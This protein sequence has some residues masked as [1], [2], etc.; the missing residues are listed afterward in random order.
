MFASVGQTLSNWRSQ[1]LTVTADT[2]ELD[3]MS[4]VPS[5]FLVKNAKGEFLPK[6]DY[7]L[8]FSEAKLILK[9][10][11]R[12]KRLEIEYRVFPFSFAKPYAH[13][14]V[15]QLEP[16]DPGLYDYFTL[17]KEEPK[18]DPFAISGLNKNGSVSRGVNFGNSQDLSVNSNLDLQ[19]SGRITEEI[20]IQAAISDNNI[21]IQADGNTLQLQEFDRVFMRLY[22][23]KSSL[24]AG[25][26][27]I[28]RPN[29]YFMNFNKKVQGGGFSTSFV[30]HDAE[31]EA[32]KGILKSAVNGAISRG[33]FARNIVPGEEG[34]Q[35]PYR[36]EGDEGENFI[37]ILSGTERVYVNGRLKKRGQDNDYVIDYNTAEITFTPNQI[38]NKDLR[39]VVEFQYADQNYA[40]SVF[41]VENKFKKKNLE[42]NFNIY[43]EQDSKNQPLQQELNDEEKRVLSEVGD[44][45]DNA[46]VSG[47]D[48]AGFDNDQVRYKLIDTLGFQDVL[49]FSK[50]PDVAIYSARFSLVGEGNGNYRQVR[51]NANGRVFE[52][53]APVNGE[54]QGNFEPVIRLISPKRRQML[55]LGGKYT[56]G[57]HTTLNVEGAMTNNDLNTFSTSDA[58]DD[59]SYGFLVELEN[60]KAIG[61]KQKTAWQNQLFYEQRGRDFQFIERYRRVEFDRDWNIR[62]LNL[63]GNE[64]LIQAKTGIQSKQNFFN[65]EFGSFIKGQDYE[66]IKNGY[67]ANYEQKGFQLESKGSYLNV[68]AN[69]NSEFLRHYTTVSQK[70]KGFKLGGYLEQERILFYEGKS[71]SLQ[72][73]SFDRVIWNAFL[74]KGDSTTANNYRLTYGE[75]YDYFPANEGLGYAVK[76]ENFDFEFG[77][78]ANPKS[79]LSAKLTYRSLTIQNSELTERHPENTLLGRVQYDLKALKGFLTSNTFYQL[80]SGFENQRE[81]SFLQV[82][83]GQ[84]THL[85]IDFNGNGIKELNEFEV[86]GVNNAFQANYIRVLTPTNEFVRVFSNQ[87]NQ[88]LF[89]R[90]NAILKE[91]KG[92]KK[93]VGLFS[94]K[95][96]YRAERETQEE[97]D[98]YNPFQTSVED[99]A[100]ISINSSFSNTLYF[101]RLGQKFG[102]EF[103]YLNNNAKN[104]L[105]NGFESRNII[106]RELRGRYNLNKV[107]AVEARYLNADRGTRSE[108]FTNRNFTIQS[109]E[110]E[111]KLIYQPSVRFRI[112]CSAIYAERQNKLGPEA[113]IN[114]SA[115]TELRFNDAGKGTFSVRAS[116]IN[117]QFNA[118]ENNSLAFEMLDGLTAGANTTWEVF[119][120]RTLA[121]NLQLNLNYNGRKSEGLRT[122]HAG[123]MQIRAFF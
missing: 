4:I 112:S 41:F 83:D 20:N 119:W 16:N 62:G 7:T 106:Q 72:S 59:Q 116:F 23:E 89:L 17:K 114:R 47:I 18:L 56:W 29:S 75:V 21:P 46:V 118:A 77:L 61:K 48:T 43:S 123:G 93:I 74:E 58:K 117:I 50:D 101:N 96:A 76:S 63:V 32:D 120:Q 115:T 65:Y 49:V 36:L 34:N 57:D 40:R 102:M 14:T 73:N 98:S 3:S 8:N 95:S 85:W 37:I 105:T 122:I 81:F 38:I 99:T 52:F 44:D 15:D 6:E 27:L 91:P 33:K 103:F 13:K 94:N 54:A 31:K 68:E 113:S 71:D 108:F 53:V 10:K 25:D 9:K 88:V 87:F 107:Y 109:N 39:I 104:L 2:M 45:L 12:G 82:N 84:G 92:W 26:F 60:K 110:I 69:N 19:L 11:Y 79:R 1:S 30:T 97:K 111:P 80:G 64:Y 66:G 67:S 51:S 90:P 100:L 121:K 78:G 35:G 5:S 24:I 86:A 70:V 22:N 42:I 55:T 28:S